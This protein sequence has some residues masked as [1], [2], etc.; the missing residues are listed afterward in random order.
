[1]R[2]LPR[3]KIVPTRCPDELAQIDA[4]RRLYATVIDSRNPP[5]VANHEQRVVVRH[6]SD[7]FH[8]QL[9]QEFQ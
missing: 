6:L 3:D 1:M 2:Q 4:G 5:P 8:S 9:F 7:L